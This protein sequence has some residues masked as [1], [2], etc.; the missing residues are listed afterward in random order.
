MRQ[1]L[2]F[3][4]LMCA[5]VL[6]TFA[7]ASMPAVSVAADNDT[8]VICTGYGMKTVSLSDLGLESGTADDLHGSDGLVVSAQCVLC[9][10]GHSALPVPP[11][12]F[13]TATD[14]TTKVPQAPPAE[15]PY[16]ADRFSPLQARAPPLSNV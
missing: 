11:V 15:S 6:Q 5:F 3:M 9:Q 1:R 8:L 2:G 13:Q 4:A 16:S 12:A 7:M 10:L 14:L